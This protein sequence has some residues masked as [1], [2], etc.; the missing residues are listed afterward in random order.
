MGMAHCSFVLEVSPQERHS[1]S[2]ELADAFRFLHR[3]VLAQKK[4]PSQITVSFWQKAESIFA[5]ETETF[6]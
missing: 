2:R 5:R 3:D 6:L 4:P 1:A